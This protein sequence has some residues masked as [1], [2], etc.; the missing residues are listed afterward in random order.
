M[1]NLYQSIRRL[2]RARH[3]EQ[4]A[5]QRR[6]LVTSNPDFNRID[7]MFP[8]TGELRRELYPKHM[9]F[10]AAG[11]TYNER[12]F[13][14]GNRIGKTRAGACEMAYHL[15]GIYPL[16]WEGKRFDTPIEAWAA[17]SSAQTTRDILQAQLLGKPAPDAGSLAG[18]PIG[19]GTGMIRGSCIADIRKGVDGAIETA[20]I[21]HISGGVSTLGFKSYKQGIQSFAGTAKHVVWVDEE[22]P[23]DIY[24]ECL[25]RTMTTSG[26]I[27]LTFTPL[28]G[29]TQTVLHFLPA[30]RLDYELPAANSAAV[31]PADSD[32]STAT[33]PMAA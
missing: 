22:C 14:A 19:L 10:F 32:G 28:Q 33:D 2:E 31:S 26:I 1:A 21:R 15:T 24:I 13:M 4:A 7:Q 6:L 18:E 8:D 5:E 23:F 20:W 17:G 11:A 16:W 3:E 27:Y 12:A 30:L 25:T 29:M 9:E